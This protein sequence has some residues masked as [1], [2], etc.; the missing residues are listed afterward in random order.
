MAAQ[1]P[2]PNVPVSAV[3]TA[4]P[5]T[6]EP[7][8]SLSDAAE[9]LLQGGFRHLPV[10][11]ADGRP[12]GIISE[13]DVRASLG[14]DLHGFTQA[15]VEALAEPV[16]GVMTPDP[17]VLRLDAPLAEALETFADERVGAILVVDEGERLRG[18]LSYV[19]VLLWLR[20]HIGGGAAPAPARPPARRRTKP[21]KP[22]ARRPVSRRAASRRRGR[23]RGRR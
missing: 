6:V 2:F 11:G 16:L 23:R 7:D 13:R 3:M 4:A 8:A 14:T 19:D 22:Q 9:A 12:V 1:S 17:I 5:A 10:I 21:G 15:T 18:I 20:D